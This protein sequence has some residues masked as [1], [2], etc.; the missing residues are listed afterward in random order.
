MNDLYINPYPHIPSWCHSNPSNDQWI[1][2]RISTLAYRVLP[3]AGSLGIFLFNQSFRLERAARHQL[4]ASVIMGAVGVLIRFS[5]VCMD[6]GPV[7]W[8]MLL[9]GDV[10]VFTTLMTFFSIIGAFTVR[11]HTT[12][13]DPFSVT[14][15]VR[16]GLCASVVLFVSM[17]PQPTL[18]ALAVYLLLSLSLPDDFFELI[19]FDITAPAL[20]VAAIVRWHAWERSPLEV[21]VF[22]AIIV[23]AWSLTVMETTLTQSRRV[24]ASISDRPRIVRA[25]IH[26]LGDAPPVYAFVAREEGQLDT[27]GGTIETLD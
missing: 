8:P 27:D 9:L 20:P 10:L 12:H 16:V 21:S 1:D 11:A 3:Y 25:S 22:V 14:M 15:V 2:N 26:S 18:V 6:M 7:V 17:Q 4:T 24:R 5:Q 13:I 19:F 23:L